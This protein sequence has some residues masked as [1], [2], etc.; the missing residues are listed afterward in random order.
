MKILLVYPQYPNTFWSFKPAL[1]FV[2]TKALMPPLG[3]LTIASLFGNDYELK[4]ID[5]NVSSITDADILWAD[6]VFIS[7]MITQKESAKDVIFKCKNLGVKMVAGGPL[8]S[9]LS[10]E[11]PEVDHFILNEGEITLQLFLEDLK[12]VDQGGDLQKIYSSDERPDIDAVPIPKWD[13]INL[14][15]YAK[16]PLQFSRGCP[17]DCEFCNISTLNGKVPRVK[18]PTQ[19]MRELNSLYDYGWRGAIFIVDDNFISNKNNAK[20]LL[21]ELISWRKE[22]NY[23]ATYTTQ[24][25]LNLADDGE[26]LTLMQQAGFSSVFIG[27]ETPSKNSLEE[28]G[29]FHNKNRDM[30]KDIKKIH[31]YGMEV[32]GGFIIG[33]DSDDETIFDAQF[34]F[35]Q[36]TGIVVAMVGLLTALPGTRLYSRFKSENR[37]IMESSGDN[38]DF[39]INFVPK[40]G[41]D[42]LISEYK[43][44]LLSLYS[45]ENYYDRVLNFL[46]EYKYHNLGKFNLSGS[47]TFYFLSLFLKAIYILGIKDKNRFYFWKMFLICLFK[48]PTSLPKFIT[49]AIYFVHFEKTFANEIYEENVEEK[50]LL[51]MSSGVLN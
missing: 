10:H 45:V 9:N 40:M 27:L 28:C 1:K 43:K 49:H 21:K 17:F 31:N 4:L 42:F 19:F 29:K 15:D 50:E 6:Y 22:K 36:E 30:V 24:I 33:F 34:K 48:F 41:K 26:L 32:Y 5:M 13:L 18:S 46:K 8:F 12:N 14:N 16:M 7:A 47:M 39:S 44:L 51:P 37:L 20:A 25:S 11:F 35:I 3:L 2:N 38:M 23:S